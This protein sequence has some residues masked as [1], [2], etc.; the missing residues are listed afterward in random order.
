MRHSVTNPPQFYVTAPHPCPYLDNRR[1][2]KLFTALQGK[3]STK[4]NNILSKQGFRRSQNV[5]YR[6]SCV[7][8][9][10]CMSARIRVDD[11]APSKSQ[12]RVL[13]QNL[14][15]SREIGAPWATEAQFSLFRKYLDDRHNDGGMADMDIFEFAAM[16]EETTVNTQIITYKDT[17]DNLVCVCLIDVLD[18]GLSMVYSFFD[19]DM[20]RSSLGTFMILD[21]VEI[22][23]SKG[24]Q[25]VYMG[26]WVRGSKKMDYKS[27]FSAVEVF[28]RNQ[29]RPIETEQNRK[30]KV[31]PLAVDPISEQI[32]QIELPDTKPMRK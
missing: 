21:N 4:L 14:Q 8:C 7:H 15:L 11:F 6:P 30:N 22:A 1:E 29:W 24:L 2:R 19:P 16:I 3:P 5:L 18:D 23:R 25:Y 31:H 26:Y 12:R 9:A 32:A 20:A 28:S 27:H 10:A 13:R 17:Q